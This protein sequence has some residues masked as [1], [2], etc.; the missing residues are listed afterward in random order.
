MP[1]A[2]GCSLTFFP[3]AAFFACI[4]WARAS[5]ANLFCK[6]LKNCGEIRVG[7][8]IK[9]MS[10]INHEYHSSKSPRDTHKISLAGKAID[11]K[12]EATLLIK[13]CDTSFKPSR[14]KLHNWEAVWFNF[15]TQ[16]CKCI[17]KSNK[18]RNSSYRLT[19]LT[20]LSCL[21]III[22]F[23]INSLPI[24]K[25]NHWIELAFPYFFTAAINWS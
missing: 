5:L 18:S 23:L 24:N 10:T 12:V 22:K 7:E 9:I 8:L 20:S 1:F 19:Y 2:D 6:A 11:N 17:N 3:S 14:I 25:T 15:K 4:S 21:I 13:L 16:N